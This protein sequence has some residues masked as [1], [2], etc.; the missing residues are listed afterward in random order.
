MAGMLCL[1]EEIDA[2]TGKEVSVDGPQGR[3]CIA[4]F[5]TG[6]T[7]RAFLNVCPHMGRSLSFA[8]DEF[9]I[10]ASGELVCPHHG[11]CFDLATG[12]CVSGPCKG[13]SLTAVEVDVREG[14][15]VLSNF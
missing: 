10:E 4:L 3:Q 15:V 14:R 13:S 5:R 9:L 11:A 7:I 6:E 1:F 8:P 12:A 2:E